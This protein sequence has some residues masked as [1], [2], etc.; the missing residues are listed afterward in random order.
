LLVFSGQQDRDFSIFLTDDKTIAG[1]NL[2]CFG[3]D[4]PTNV[5]SFSYP[6][7][8]RCE[9]AGELI[10]SV[11]RAQEE[12][13]AAG[14]PFPERLVALIIHGLLHALG[15]HHESGGAE[16]RRMRHREKKLLAYAK[17]LPDYE[18]IAL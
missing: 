4:A 15:Y 1:L 16:A 9:L 13:K 6:D 14:W 3:K 7:S 12:A 10:I 17:S 18:K 5:I 8:F 11:E 2:R